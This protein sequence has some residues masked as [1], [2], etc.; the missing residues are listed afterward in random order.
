MLLTIK[1]YEEIPFEKLELNEFE[2]HKKQ[3]K[4]NKKL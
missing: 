4:Q 2:L 1:N 3:K